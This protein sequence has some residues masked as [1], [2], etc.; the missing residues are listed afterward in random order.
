MKLTIIIPVFN[1]EKTIIPILKEIYA[2]VFPGVTKEVVIVNDASTDTTDKKIRMFLKK[3]KTFRYVTHEKNQGKGAAV[4]TGIAHASGDYIIIQDADLEY[5]PKDINKL[6]DGLKTTG[7]KIIYGTRLNHSP[8]F[9]KEQRTF[10][11]FLH[12]LGN[13]GL[14]LITSMLYGQYLTDMETCYKL[15]PRKIIIDIPLHARGFEIEPEITAK[16]LKRGYKVAE[17]SISTNPRGYEE[18]K[19]LNTFKD[20]YKALY[21]LLR[22]RFIE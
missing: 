13:R 5:N 20:G 12:Y 21:T 16:I 11:F 22:Y 18:G 2:V 15:I 4:R 7:A 1:E 3:H 6:L 19:K 14:S 8:D 10:R 9:K 17:I